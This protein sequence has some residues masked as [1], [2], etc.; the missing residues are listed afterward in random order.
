MKI[1]RKK[2]IS[3][4]YLLLALSIVCLLL[5]GVSAFRGESL[6]PVRAF[7][8]KI[9]TPMQQ[10][11]NNFGQW[12]WDKFQV[13]GDV[14]ELRAEN[15]ALQE[16]LDSYKNELADNQAELAELQELRDLYELDQMYPDYNMTAARIFSTNS[17][18]WFNEFYI[19]KGL[20]D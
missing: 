12:V 17:S 4:K 20:N 15:E 2:D 3:P 8:G 10:G 14:E 7:T 5:I 9:I 6:R 18:S 11:I 19:D 13:F 1:D 16:E